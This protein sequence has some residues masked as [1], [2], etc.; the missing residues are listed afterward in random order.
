M[1]KT[2]GPT[3]TGE[4]LVDDFREEDIAWSWAKREMRRRYPRC[5]FKQNR[6]GVIAWTKGR[7]VG[8]FLF[9][10]EGSEVSL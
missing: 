8:L 6:H 5:R 4:L 3:V 2:R 7:W 1:S 10:V 9:D